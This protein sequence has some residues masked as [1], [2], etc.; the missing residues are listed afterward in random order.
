MEFKEFFS[1]QAEIPSDYNWSDLEVANMYFYDP[2]HKVREICKVTGKSIGEIYR[3][4]SRYGSLPNRRRDNRGN[5]IALSDSGLPIHQVA[6]LTG[7]T[8]RH[9]RNILKDNG[10]NSE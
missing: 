5:V 1:L 7:Y 8:S 6:Q 9:V 3:I 4:L 10:N 2:S